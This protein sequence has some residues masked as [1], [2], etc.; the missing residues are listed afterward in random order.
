VLFPCPVFEFIPCYTSQEQG[1]FETKEGSFMLG[2]WWEF[3]DGQIAIPELLAPTF[4]KQ[5][6]EGTPFRADSSR[7][8]LGPVFLCPHFLWHKEGRM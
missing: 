6:H 5:F 3:T 7:G 2:W 8:H 4:V 1:W